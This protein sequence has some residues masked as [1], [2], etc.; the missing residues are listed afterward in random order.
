MITTSLQ[1]AE[2]LQ[3]SMIFL[4]SSLDP[5]LR[6]L[7][8]FCSFVPRLLLILFL[9]SP[10]SSSHGAFCVCLQKSLLFIYFCLRCRSSL[11]WPPLLLFIP[12]AQVQPWTAARA[13][14]P[15]PPSTTSPPCP[16]TRPWPQTPTAAW[17]PPRD[18]WGVAGDYPPACA[19]PCSSGGEE[20][21]KYDH[22]NKTTI[23]K[24]II[25]I[26]KDDYILN[27]NVNYERIG[28]LMKPVHR[29]LQAALV[30]NEVNELRCN[31]N[32]H[33]VALLHILYMASKW[34]RPSA[35]TCISFKVHFWLASGFPEQHLRLNIVARWAAVV[36]TT[37]AKKKLSPVLY[38]IALLFFVVFLTLPTHPIHNLKC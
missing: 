29:H 2:S 31:V 21:D 20:P 35:S 8:S 30:F 22:Q 25:K 5:N 19:T 14:L 18:P 1:T 27:E 26:Q 34:T 36:L 38:L 23:I 7:S 3:S 9:S 33:L 32:D 37:P 16:P 13:S 6:S 24:M 12:V 15:P 17:R 11:L 28:K 10:N 4:W